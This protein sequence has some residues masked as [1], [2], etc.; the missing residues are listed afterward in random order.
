M[1]PRRLAD[2]GSRILLRILQGEAQFRLL[3]AFEGA[4]ETRELG[5]L[6]TFRIH[7]DEDDRFPRH[8]VLV[9]VLDEEQ[10]LVETDVGHDVF[11]AVQIGRA[12]CRERVEVY[13]R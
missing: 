7:R 4:L 6:E 11:N 5:W 2:S 9:H 12:S 8:D 13:V 1:R 3:K 10:V